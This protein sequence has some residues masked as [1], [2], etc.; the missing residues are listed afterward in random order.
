MPSNSC[1]SRLSHSANSIGTLTDF[2]VRRCLV[3]LMAASARL[4][5]QARRAVLL[6][7]PQPLTDRGHGGGKEARGGFDATLLGAF[8]QTQAMV[9]GV[10]FHFTNQIEVTGR[11][12]PRI[13]KAVP[14]S[15]P[16]KSRC[17]E[18]QT[19][20]SHCAWKSR[21]ARGISTFPPPR[22]RSSPCPLQQQLHLPPPLFTQAFQSR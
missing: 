8:D 10:L 13:V 19:P 22:R 20:V 7:T 1:L 21:T 11:H 5:G 3:R 12:G 17:V 16:W 14:R 18:N 2:A 15:R 6:K 4:L 9:I